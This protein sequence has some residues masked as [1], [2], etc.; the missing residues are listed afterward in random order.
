[1]CVSLLCVHICQLPHPCFPVPLFL[2]VF[3]AGHS[4]TGL[5]AWMLSTFIHLIHSHLVSFLREHLYNF[6]LSCRKVGGL[7][8]PAEQ[9]LSVF[10]LVRRPS[11]SQCLPFHHH[12]SPLPASLQPDPLDVPSLTETWALAHVEPLTCPLAV[13]PFI[14]GKTFKTPSP[15]LH[16]LCRLPSATSSGQLQRFLMYTLFLDPLYHRLL[17]VSFVRVFLLQI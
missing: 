10:C 12:L 6:I 5:P 15:L 14:E 16:G 3:I 7:S 9:N 2:P 13:L 4:S 11:R 17:P 8:F 1:M